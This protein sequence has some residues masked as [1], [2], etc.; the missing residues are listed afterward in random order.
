[1]VAVFVSGN[2]FPMLG[3][4]P[5]RGRLLLPVDDQPN[6][7]PVVVMSGNF[8]QRQFHS[9]PKVVGSILHLNGVAFTVVGVTPVDYMG[10]L[11]N[12]PSLWAPVAARVQVGGL[13]AQ[14]LENRLM[15]AGMPMGRLRPGV[16]LSDAQAELDVLAA[17]LR[18]AH[19]EEERDRGVVLLAARNAATM[20]EPE[21][22]A[23]IAA[24]MS[25]V[26]LLL[27]IACANVA[28]LLLARAAVRRKEIAVR[29]AIGAS[30]RRLLRQLLTESL[31]I[32]LFAGAIGL[33]LPAGCCSF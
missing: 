28:S 4:V 14:D 2:Y 21:D 9:D 20:F 5:L 27:L 22:W 1:M 31:L 24:V 6:S 7:P 29:L 10:T 30:R 8:W 11:P 19:P 25:A 32:A 15:I 23:L 16:L 13:S 26:G 33:P 18:T 12:V 17:Q 3:A